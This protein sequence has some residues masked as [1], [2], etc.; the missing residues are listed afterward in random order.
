MDKLARDIPKNDF[1]NEISVRSR[2]ALRHLLRIEE[3]VPE[4]VAT[5]RLKNVEA[6]PG[7]GKSGIK[8]VRTAL[9]RRGLDFQ[10]PNESKKKAVKSHKTSRKVILKGTRNNVVM[11]R[12][13]KDILRCCAV[14][15]SATFEHADNEFTPLRSQAVLDLHVKQLSRVIRD[16]RKA[17]E[18]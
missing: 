7:I 4:L 6:I 9:Q 13:H 15:M 14:I 17:Y 10:E 11:H 1:E 16:L 2:N 18:N 3:L 5:E 12:L 8:Q